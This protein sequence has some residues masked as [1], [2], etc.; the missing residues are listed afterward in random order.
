MRRAPTPPL[1]PYPNVLDFILHAMNGVKGEAIMSARDSD[2]KTALNTAER[3]TALI[4][5]LRISAA[6]IGASAPVELT[7]FIGNNSDFLSSLTLLNTIRFPMDALVPLA[8]RLMIFSGDSGFAGDAMQRAKPLL[9]G[10]EIVEFADYPAAAWT[11]MAADHKNDVTENLLSFL[12]R[13]DV[14]RPA[15]RLSGPNRKGEAGGITFNVTGTGPAVLLFPAQLAPSQWN[16]L[17]DRISERFTVIRLGGANLGMMAMLENRGG[18]RSFIR[19]LRGMLRDARIEPTDK[20]LE[21][22]CGSGIIARWLAREGL[23]AQPITAV[24]INPFLLGEAE[25]LSDMDGLSHAIDFEHGNAEDLPFPDNAFD[26]VLSVTVLE[27]CDADQAIS[28]M[29]RVIRPGGRIAVMVRACDMPVFWN[30]PL[31]PNIKEKAEAPMRHVAPSGCADG[32]LM[33]RMS[34]AGLEDVVAYPSFHGCSA[35]LRNYEPSALSHL[36]DEEQTAWHAAKA[37]AV[38][39]DTFFMMHPAHCAIGT[40][41]G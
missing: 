6:H 8:G 39:N 2:G 5:N 3:I 19:V 17:I 13:Q 32:S 16:P 11:D 26:A 14:L 1:S 22:G 24:D 27:E 7:Q 35:F 34:A 4:D 18:D 31:D 40:K 36:N 41:P 23:C 28:E 25:T 15:T 38:K 9:S 37:E 12:E 21:V 20:L 33:G 29:M 30:L 10:A